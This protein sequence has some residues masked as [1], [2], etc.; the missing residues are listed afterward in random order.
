MSLDLSMFMLFICCVKKVKRLFHQVFNFCM[1]E[2]YV[3]VFRVA[4]PPII[5]PLGLAYL[6]FPTLSFKTLAMESIKAGMAVKTL[7][8]ASHAF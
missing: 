7:W 3:L 2:L 4:L 5:P 6:L 8:L 1:S